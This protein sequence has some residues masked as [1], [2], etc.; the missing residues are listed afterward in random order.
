MLVFPDFVVTWRLDVSESDQ[1]M[2]DLSAA[3]EGASTVVDDL[4]IANASGRLAR[5]LR[6]Q[7]V[8]EAEIARLRLLLKG[9][10]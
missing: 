1:L 6:K 5:L 4:T 3:P 9:V 8:L 10:L 2:M 7:S